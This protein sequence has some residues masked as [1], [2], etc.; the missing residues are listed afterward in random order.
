MKKAINEPTEHNFPCQDYG[1]CEQC[2]SFC[3]ALV[4]VG[5]QIIKES[6]EENNIKKEHEHKFVPMGFHWFK[7]AVWLAILAFGSLYL[8]LLVSLLMV[9]YRIITYSQ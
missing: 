5:K 2:Q 9:L 1:N 7:I 8:F 3:Q 6:R 4:K